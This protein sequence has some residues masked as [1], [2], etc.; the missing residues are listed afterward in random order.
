MKV[1]VQES[2]GEGNHTT[3]RAEPKECEAYD[4]VRE[5]MPLRNGKQTHQHNLVGDY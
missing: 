2:L 3:A 1:S 4:H 5:M